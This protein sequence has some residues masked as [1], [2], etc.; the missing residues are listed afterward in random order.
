MARSRASADIRP[1][2]GVHPVRHHRCRRPAEL[3]RATG[4]AERR[5]HRAMAMRA[6][7]HRAMALGGVGHASWTVSS[8]DAPLTGWR[9]G[10]T[11]ETGRRGTGPDATSRNGRQKSLLDLDQILQTLAEKRPLFHSEADFQHA[12]AWEIHKVI[13]TASIRLE[14]PVRVDTSTVHLDLLVECDHSRYPIELKYK[15]AAMTADIGGEKF[16]LSNQS[17]Q[18][19]GRYD[20]LKDVTRLERYV[21]SVENSIGYAIFLSND[22]LYWNEPRQTITSVEFS[23]HDTRKV[24]PYVEM[25]WAPHAGPGSLKKREEAIACKFNYSCFWKNYYKVDD[26]QFKY[27]LLTVEQPSRG[28]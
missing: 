6:E 21:T 28:H 20:F 14:L 2:H 24:H 1:A 25:R 22:C 12:L 7:R 27:L 16:S 17:A 23:I 3:A 8:R 26:S 9:G 13:P 19:T 11:P 4:A 5:W 18:D 15:A 10:S